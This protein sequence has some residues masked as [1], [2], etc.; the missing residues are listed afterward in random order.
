MSEP[1]RP[2]RRIETAYRR[3]ISEAFARLVWPKQEDMSE[4]DWFSRIILMSRSYELAEQGAKIAAQ[5]VRWVNIENAKSW[6]HASRQSQRSQFLYRLL[7]EE[8]SGATGKRLH[9]IVREN[10]DLITSIPYTAAA[11]LTNEI[12]AAQQAGARHETI[13]RMMRER[14]PELT[15]NRIQL[16]ARTES[17]KAS[18][19]LTRARSEDLNLDWF[20]WKSAED[21]RVRPAHKNLNGVLVSWHDLPAPEALVGIKST[22]GKYGPGEAPN[23]FTGDT[24]VSSPSGIERLW[25]AP[26]SGDIIDIEIE[27]GFW[28]SATPN[29]P[30][31]TEYGWVPVCHL[32]KGDYLLQAL[33]GRDAVV[34]PDVDQHI[35]T[36]EDVFNAASLRHAHSTDFGLDFHGDVIDDYIDVV[37]VKRELNDGLEASAAQSPRDFN[38][39]WADGWITQLVTRVALQISE[40]RSSRVGQ[41]LAALFDRQFAHSDFVGFSSGADHDL[42][43]EQSLAYGAAI[44][45]EE[46]SDALLTPLFAEVERAEFSG[47]NLMVESVDWRFGSN[48]ACR[49]LVA[50]PVSGAPQELGDRGNTHSFGQKRSRA[51]DKRVRSFGGHVYTLQSAAGWYGVTPVMIIAKNCRCYPAPLLSIEDAYSSGSERRRVYTDGRIQ[52]LTRAQFARISNMPTRFAA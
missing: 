32:N 22:L 23:C 6:K 13:A 18:T 29:H 12:A 14:F 10:A 41:Q 7:Q 1:F 45:F 50:Q 25:R 52:R 17:S 20:E 44:D 33:A 46:I 31:L 40:P 4:S 5:M 42:F 38:L 15:R 2:L 19:A 27:G 48:V 51:I 30:I 9:E 36:F 39:A 11:Q 16:I 8:L 49:Q 35:A 28:F 3:A 47:R 24:P 43:G 21:F 37:T 26:Y 34:Q